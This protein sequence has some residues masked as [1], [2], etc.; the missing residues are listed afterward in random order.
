MTEEPPS[1][2]RRKKDSHELQALGAALVELNERE[3]ASVELP[4]ALLD[5][6]L[7]ARQITA[8]GARRRQLQYIGKLM[9]SVDPGPIREKLSA[10][11]AVSCTQT[12]RLHSIESWRKRLL[13]DE[14]ALAELSE[15]YPRA[16]AAKLGALVDNTL[17]ERQAG[18]PPKNF[19]AL[20]QA[21]DEVIAPREKMK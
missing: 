6:V 5:A 4:E 14:N 13:E 15:A 21:L 2:T 18:R 7:Q 16:D 19:R 8:F 20:F 9:R 12:A 11:E 1:K 17:N 10:W 3:L